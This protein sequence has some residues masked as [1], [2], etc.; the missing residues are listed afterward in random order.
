MV[1]STSSATAPPGVTYGSGMLP[2]HDHAPVAPGCRW[3]NTRSPSTRMPRRSPSAI[4][5]GNAS[6]GPEAP[7]NHVYTPNVAGGPAVSCP[8]PRVDPGVAPVGVVRM[9][10]YDVYPV[11]APAFHVRQ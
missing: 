6:D 11:P 7:E 8:R 4:V 9:F 2:M 10:R 1:D 5:N 3:K